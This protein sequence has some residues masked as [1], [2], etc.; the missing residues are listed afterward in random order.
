MNNLKIILIS[1]SLSMDAFSA[2]VCKCLNIKNNFKL[3]SLIISLSFS[4]FQMIMPL[5]GYFLGNTLSDKLINFNHI[6]AFVLLSVVGINMIKESYKKEDLNNNFNFKELITLSIATSIDALS[7]GITFSFFKINLVKTI[8]TIGITCFL[9]SLL[10]CF[11]GK[12]I[13]N[14]INNLANII[15]GV[16]LIL[17]G[18]KILLEHFVFL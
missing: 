5:I 2:S 6:I 14:K 12:V 8:I 7:V 11:I 17:I 3:T 9:L 13:G 16:I 15:G 10:G 1:L 4:I 18:L